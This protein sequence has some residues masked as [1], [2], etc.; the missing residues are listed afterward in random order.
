MEELKNYLLKYFDDLKKE[1]RDKCAEKYRDLLLLS[2]LGQRIDCEKV[3]RLIV[4][5]WSHAGLSYIK[6]NAWFPKKD[7]TGTVWI[8]AKNNKFEYDVFRLRYKDFGQQ[9]ASGFQ[10]KRMRLSI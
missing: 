2:E 7:R 6:E 10:D 9:V 5:R 4:S 8:V 3:N 1:T